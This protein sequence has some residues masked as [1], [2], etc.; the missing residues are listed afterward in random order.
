MH[1]IKKMTLGLFAFGMTVLPPISVSADSG[2]YMATKVEGK[3]A[4]MS[5]A[6]LRDTLEG[7]AR[8]SG[9]S[10]IW[11]QESDYRIR[12]SATFAGDFETAVIDLVDSIH[13]D[14]PELSVVLYRGNAVVHIENRYASGD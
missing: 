11:D 5:G 14:N 2:F 6:S 13:L 7:W 8:S 12:S 4:V 10:V 1:M 9:W 3:Y